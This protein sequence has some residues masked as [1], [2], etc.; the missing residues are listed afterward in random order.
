MIPVN[1]LRINNYVYYNNEYNELGVITEIK[2][3]LIPKINYVGINNR[4]D[5]YYQTKHINPIPLSEKWLL[6]F[7]FFIIKTNGTIEATLS[8]FRY[9]IQTA[10]N[11]NGF[12][13]C[14]G[15]NVLINFNYVH[16]LQNLYNAL[17]REELT[18]NK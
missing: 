16:E 14:D 18:L 12:F 1:E 11:Y 4:V 9:S 7:G 17:C 10:E 6:N 13:F 8:T 2:T 5:V 3:S 15:E